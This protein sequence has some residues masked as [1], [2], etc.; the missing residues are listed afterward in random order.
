MMYGDQ[1]LALGSSGVTM[2]EIQQE[3][4]VSHP[5]MQQLF[6]IRFYSTVQKS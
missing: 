1:N 2:V 3:P 6:F 4:T 5:F